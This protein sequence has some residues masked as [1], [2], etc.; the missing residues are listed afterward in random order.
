MEENWPFDSDGNTMDLLWKKRR[1]ER[2]R[3]QLITSQKSPKALLELY[4]YEVYQQV[5]KERGL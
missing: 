2:E 1:R 3:D 4:Y 5:F